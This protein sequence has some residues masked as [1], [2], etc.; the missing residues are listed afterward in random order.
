MTETEIMKAEQET[1]KVEVEEVDTESASESGENEEQDGETA[2]Q[3]I[4]HTYN[5]ISLVVQFI[6]RFILFNYWYSFTV[7]V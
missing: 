7:S 2:G 1:E 4:N 6:F 5:Y 3:V